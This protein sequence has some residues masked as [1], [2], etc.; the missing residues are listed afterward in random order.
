M[1]GVIRCTVAAA[2][3]MWLKVNSAHVPCNEV[4]T[5]GSLIIFLAAFAQTAAA[6]KPTSPLL[7]TKKKDKIFT[8]HVFDITNFKGAT[9][10]LIFFT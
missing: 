10:A 2:Q 1:T 4:Q 7:H 9:T 6:L 5:C 3:P 8:Y